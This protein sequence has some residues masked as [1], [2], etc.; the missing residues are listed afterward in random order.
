MENTVSWK[1]GCLQVWGDGNVCKYV[2]DMTL[3]VTVYTPWPGCSYPMCIGCL[4]LYNNKYTPYL[5]RPDCIQSF[6]LHQNWP[7]WPGPESYVWSDSSVTAHCSSYTPGMVLHQALT[8]THLPCNTHGIFKILMCYSNRPDHCND[9][10]KS[11]EN[12]FLTCKKGAWH[13]M[14]GGGHLIHSVHVDLAQG[15][16]FLYNQGCHSTY[17]FCRNSYFSPGIYT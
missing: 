11:R 9:P 7:S 1:E 8:V 10:S 5:H 13:F 15:G 12:L 2:N 16:S 6:V 14:G 3:V 4:D 17:Y